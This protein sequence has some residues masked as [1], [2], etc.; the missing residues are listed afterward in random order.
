M[1][2]NLLRGL[3][4]VYHEQLSFLF[5]KVSYRHIYGLIHLFF[6][7]LVYICT[8]IRL[9]FYKLLFGCTS[10]HYYSGSSI[11]NIY[12]SCYCFSP[13]LIW[14]ILLIHQGTSNFYNMSI[15]PLYNPIL[16]RGTFTWIYCINS[17]ILQV[18]INSSEKYSPPSI[19]PSTLIYIPFSF[20]PLL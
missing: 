7:F 10:M 14:H 12:R 5:H 6:P 15:F 17:L 13:I 3:K 9:P 1:F 18:F 2:I 16:L 8:K 11:H 4:I 20:P 19:R